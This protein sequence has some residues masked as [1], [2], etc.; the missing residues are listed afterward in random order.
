MKQY[1]FWKQS[2]GRPYRGKDDKHAPCHLLTELGKTATINSE[3]KISWS[4]FWFHLKATPAIPSSIAI[5]GADKKELNSFDTRTIV[6]QA[7]KSQITK[8]GGRKPLSHTDLIAEVNRLASEYYRKQPNG[9]VLVSSYSI[10][11]FPSRAIKVGNCVISALGARGKR[12]PYPPDVPQHVAGT[13]ISAH[14]KSTRYQSIKVKMQA[15]TE[16]EAYSSARHALDLLRALWTLF[17]THGSWSMSFRSTAQ[18]QGIIHAGPLETMHKLDGTPVPEFWCD[19]EYTIDRK[20]FVPKSGWDTLERDRKWAQKQIAKFPKPQE[21]ENLLVR[22]VNAL[23]H[24]VHDIAYLH[25]WS[26]IEKITDT[27]GAK[28]DET[29][30]RASRIFPD[31]AFVREIIASLRLRRNEIVH[32]GKQ[33][34]SRDQAVN[35]IKSIVDPHFI[36]LIRNDFGVASLQEYAEVLALP[37]DRTTLRKR[38]KQYDKM[39]KTRGLTT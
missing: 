29:V 28:Y 7:I 24:A 38:W 2:D 20:N 18:P 39:L 21:I 13:P 22:Y 26:I 36:S 10:D 33:A 12:F 27:I 5:I 1:A 9:Y 4:N 14:F 23:D 25:I 17:A 30:A 11:S 34:Q 32:A 8:L 6:Q 31:A 37:T 16:H 15:R 19:L 3:G 35:L